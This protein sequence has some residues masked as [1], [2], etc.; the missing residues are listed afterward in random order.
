[1]IITFQHF[2]IRC[3]FFMSGE[4][5]AHGRLRA[6]RRQLLNFCHFCLITS[7]IVDVQQ[8]VLLFSGEYTYEVCR[9]V[10]LVSVA[11]GARGAARQNPLA[12]GRHVRLQTQLTKADS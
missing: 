3:G 11:G 4:S 12:E 5:R 9:F 10:D 6:D 1:V 2:C 8:R 7:L